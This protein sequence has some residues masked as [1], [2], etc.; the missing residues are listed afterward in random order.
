MGLLLKSSGNGLVLGFRNDGSTLF[1]AGCDNNLMKV[2]D[3]EQERCSWKGKVAAKGIWPTAISVP[4]WEWCEKMVVVGASDGSVSLIDTRIATG[5]GAQS[6]ILGKHKHP[7]VSTAH[8]L[9]VG[10]GRGETI[11]SADCEGE[12]ILWDPRKPE[13][14]SKPGSEADRIHVRA[15]KTCLTTMAAH[16]SG[17]FIASGSTAKCV[18]V[19]GASTSEKDHVMIRSR[20]NRYKLK[21]RIA[22]VTSLAFHQQDYILAVG[23]SDGTVTM[24]GNE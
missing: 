4:P 16:P 18:K 12:I 3:L 7:I 20:R 23:C 11:V 17:N 10:E 13:N 19:F 24:Y 22:P 1:A 8:G 2:W 5:N 21:E 6:R 14:L 15:H 9:W